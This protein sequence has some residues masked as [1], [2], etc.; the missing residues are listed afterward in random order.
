MGSTPAWK[1]FVGMFLLVVSGGISLVWGISLER[2]SPTGIMGFPGIYFGT[3]CL[4][5]HDDPYKVNNLEHAY[6]EAG[7]TESSESGALRQSVTLYVNLPTTFLFVAPLAWMPLGTAQVLW[8]TLVVG[9]FSLASFL[10]YRL[11]YQY[12]PSV[13]LLLALIVLA[14]CEII[15]AGGNT[16]GLVVSLCVISVWCFLKERYILAGEICLAASLAIKPHDA[17]LIWLYFLISGPAHR[18]RAIRS[19]ALTATIAIAAAAWVSYIAPHWASELSSNLRIISA[20]GGINDPSPTSIG[21][22]SPDMIIDLQTVVSCFTSAPEIYNPISYFICLL[23]FIIW[24]LAVRRTEHSFPTALFGLVSASALSMLVTYHRSYDAKM[25]LLAIPACAML[26]TEGKA[27]RWPALGL[28]AVALFINGDIPMAALTHLTRN[29]QMFRGGL[30][31]RILFALVARPAPLVLIA[32]AAFYL[33]VMAHS[34][35]TAGPEVAPSNRRSDSSR[36]DRER[37]GLNSP[38]I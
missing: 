31:Q 32:L 10:M 29:L 23:L 22:S 5:E 26:W 19:A 14:N 36:R 27:R 15:F 21:V 6:E 4:L 37:A 9:C 12:S 38:A 17:G 28:S 8:T 35:P 3:R 2:S 20:P 30:G 11:G 24:L 33:W 16:A 18:R 25:L 34:G 13:S 7:F 1:Q